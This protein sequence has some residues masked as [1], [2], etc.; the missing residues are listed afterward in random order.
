MAKPSSGVARDEDPVRRRRESSPNDCRPGPDVRS[1]GQWLC[2]GQIDVDRRELAL[3][4]SGVLHEALSV[5]REILGITG[6]NAGEKGVDA[7]PN[8]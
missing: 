5:E 6:L 8:R 7:P 2:G 1:Y 4:R 3:A